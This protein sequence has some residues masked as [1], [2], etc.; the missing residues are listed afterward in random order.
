MPKRRRLTTMELGPDH[1]RRLKGIQ[2]L[3]IDHEIK[4]NTRAMEYAIDFTFLALR[5]KSYTPAE[6]EILKKRK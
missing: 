3:C 2:A 6:L 5:E 1:R 4:N